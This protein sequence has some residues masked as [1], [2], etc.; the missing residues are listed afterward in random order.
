M[1]HLIRLS[2][3]VVALLL[4]S[5]SSSPP[6][7][8]ASSARP[9]ASAP[10][11]P[12]CNTVPAQFAVGQPVNAALLEKARAAAQADLARAV[13]NDQVITQEFRAGRLN[14]HLDA[15]GRVTRVS[16]G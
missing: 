2:A 3:G 5:C 7:R 16:C 13:R 1:H 10:Q 11:P 14:L 4:A 15:N 8:A 9:P 12:R 6:P